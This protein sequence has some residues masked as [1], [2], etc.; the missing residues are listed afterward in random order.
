MV[1]KGVSKRVCTL[2]SPCWIAGAVPPAAGTS[3]R[4][5]SL[6]CRENPNFSNR[7]RGRQRAGNPHAV[8]MKSGPSLIVLSIHLLLPNSPATM[9]DPVDASPHSSSGFKAPEIFSR[10]PL[11]VS[12]HEVAA[13][14]R[15]F[16][17]RG[18]DR[19]Y[20]DLGSG[21]H[22]NQDIAGCHRLSHLT[23]Y[24]SVLR[25]PGLLGIR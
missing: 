12:S 10:R 25:G 11:S 19:C 15:H 1:S 7:Q 4:P 5:P 14:S 22:G 13:L 24:V 9:N 16:F 2:S 17:H 18:P 8:C 20:P 3:Q 21:D 6:A 23:Q